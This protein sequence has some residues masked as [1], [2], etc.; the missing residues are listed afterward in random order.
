[1]ESQIDERMNLT[2]QKLLENFDE[3]VHEKLRTNLRESSEAVTKY[4]GWLWQ[5]TR[6]YLAPYAKFEVG[7]NAFTLVQNPF[8]AENIHPGPYR[9]GNLYKT[10]EIRKLISE[11][12]RGI[13]RLLKEHPA[14]TREDCEKHARGHSQPAGALP[15][16]TLQALYRDL[17]AAG[18]FLD[19]SNQGDANLYRIGHP[20]AQRVIAS[21][22]RMPLTDSEVEFQLSG[23]GKRISILEPLVG[24]SGFMR[25]LQFS[26]AALEQED[27]LFLA[28]VCDDGIPL[29]PEQ[30]RR[31]FSLAAESIGHDLPRNDKAIATLQDSISRQRNAVLQELGS[32]NVAF[33]DAELDKLDRWGEDKRNS[34]RVT[35]KELDDQIKTTK[36]EARL[37]PNLPE[38]LK[39]EREKRQL[40]ARRDEAW[41]EYEEA[42]KQIEVQKDGLMDEIEKRMRQTTAEEVLFTI[43][44]RLS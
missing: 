5:L 36:K 41:K 12:E 11:W 37:A 21:C 26:A 43:R 18:A 28:G 42:A 40:D 44:W 25:V 23:T 32:R 27:H 24:K 14:W 16:F 4:D 33:F 31:F 15:D 6:F 7:Q 1:M 34:L 35:L 10:R 2:R 30:C 19:G 13:E 22:K 3:E 8:P 9:S 29:D 17:L 20:L 39:L 38:K